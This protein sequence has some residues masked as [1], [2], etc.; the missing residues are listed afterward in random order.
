M[1]PVHVAAQSEIITNLHFR[2]SLVRYFYF[3]CR[4]FSL[5]CLLTKTK[6]YRETIVIVNEYVWI[7]LHKATPKKL[8]ARSNLNF[9]TIFRL[10]DAWGYWRPLN[11]ERLLV[12]SVKPVT[13]K[14][15]NSSYTVSRKQFDTTCHLF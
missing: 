13:P 9:L 7:I 2:W 5:S 11:F 15:S 6:Q 14:F 4:Y 3:S 8:F 1:S 10:I 12:K